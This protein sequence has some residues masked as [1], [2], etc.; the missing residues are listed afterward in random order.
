MDLLQIELVKA[1]PDPETLK[2]WLWI[3]FSGIGLLLVVLG[4][5]FRRE[6][7]SKDSSFKNYDLKFQTYT[8]EQDKR[9]K[10]FTK[11]QSNQIGELKVMVS[12]VCSNV[13][14][15]ATMVEVVKQLQADRDPRIER[16]IREHERRLNSHGQ[17]IIYIKAKIEKN[18]FGKN[19]LPN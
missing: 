15:I 9:W 19:G 16:E 3:T 10:E 17:E 18:G 5:F 13:Q 14:S 7:S 1:D 2:L 6:I 12:T 4:Y 11:E 8:E